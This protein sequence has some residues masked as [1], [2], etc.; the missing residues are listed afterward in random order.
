[1][2]ILV[3]RRSARV[4]V[5]RRPGLIDRLLLAI[6]AADYVRALTGLSPD[7]TGKIHCPFHEDRTAS[8]QLYQDGTWYCY[9]GCQAG[10]SIFDFASR[11]WRIQTKDRAFLQLRSRLADEFAIGA[12]T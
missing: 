6:P 11:V 4:G 9:G 10:G 7:R 1:M 2:P 8:L 3:P 12:P 5:H